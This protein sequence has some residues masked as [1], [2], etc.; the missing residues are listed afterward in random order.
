MVVAVVERVLLLLL[1]WLAALTLVLEKRVLDNISSNFGR[2]R[3]FVSV[4]VC[5]GNVMEVGLEVEV[6][7]GMCF[8]LPRI[9]KKKKKEPE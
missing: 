4:R 2:G 1:P 6:G 5:G 7:C 9:C 3:L 8:G